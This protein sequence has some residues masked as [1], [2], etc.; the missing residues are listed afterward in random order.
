MMTLAEILLVE[1]RR[2]NLSQ[3]DLAFKAGVHRN[4]ISAI[5]KGDLNIRLSTLGA[6]F[7]ALGYNFEIK[8]HSRE[9]SE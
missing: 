4:T 6:I 9:K 1:R 7:L 5:E 8:L 3:T 2:Q